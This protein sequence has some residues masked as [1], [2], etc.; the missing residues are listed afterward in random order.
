LAILVGEHALKEEAELITGGPRSKKR[1][2]LG[3]SSY[4]FVAAKFHF[5]ALR[6]PAI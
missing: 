1:H 4:A 5:A 3:G 6:F 2:V